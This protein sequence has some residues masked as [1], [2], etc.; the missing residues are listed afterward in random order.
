MG[1]ANSKGVVTGNLLNTEGATSGVFQA[2]AAVGTI[3]TAVVMDHVSSNPFLRYHS[4][5]LLAHSSEEGIVC[6]TM[7]SLDSLAEA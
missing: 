2:G 3:A 5:H 6:S 7:L 1:L 4:T